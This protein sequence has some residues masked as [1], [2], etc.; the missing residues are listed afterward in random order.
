VSVDQGIDLELVITI[1]LAT[2]NNY[3]GCVPKLKRVDV[4]DGLQVGPVGSTMARATTFK[5]VQDS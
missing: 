3:N 5:N 1:G 4:I 2:T